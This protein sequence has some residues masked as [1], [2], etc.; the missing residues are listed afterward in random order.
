MPIV[1]LDI[2]EGWT[3]GRARAL[4]DAVHA[5]LVAEIGIPVADRFQIIHRHR[6]AD[7]IWDRHHP[8][9]DRGADAVLVSITFRVGR[10]DAMKRALYRAIASQA[11]SRA[12][13]RADD[14]M[15]VITQNSSP[16][17]SFGGGI[18][19]Y[20]PDPTG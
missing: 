3:D 11:G 5:A 1:R 16:D 9:L 15:V 12:G 18:A 17:W 7:V 14:V 4:A 19:H 8:N 2:P 10:D 13:I 6:A 20:A